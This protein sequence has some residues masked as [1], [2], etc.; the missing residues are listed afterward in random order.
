MTKRADAVLL[1]EV[2]LSNEKWEEYINWR[3]I[4]AELVR[5]YNTA[6]GYEPHDGRGPG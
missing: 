4:V 6:V 3:A 1:A 2:L 5:A